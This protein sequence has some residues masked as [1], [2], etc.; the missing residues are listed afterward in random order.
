MDD[1]PGAVLSTVDRRC[2]Q[3]HLLQLAVDVTCEP[4]E[5]DGETERLAEPGD[6]V[7]R[8][9]GLVVERFGRSSQELAH[10]LDTDLVTADSAHERDVVGIRPQFEVRPRVTAR[11]LPEGTMA[12]LEK[13]GSLRILSTRCKVHRISSAEQAVVSWI[14]NRWQPTA[15]VPEH[16][17]RRGSIQ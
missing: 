10:P 13:L 16:M 4:L 14:R 3:R 8:I 17:V 9:P 2:P 1:L 12:A 11:V 5:L 15:T 7:L 6:E